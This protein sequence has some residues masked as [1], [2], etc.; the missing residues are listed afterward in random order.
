MDPFGEGHSPNF[1]AFCGLFGQLHDIHRQTGDTIGSFVHDEQNQF[2][3]MFQKGWD[4]L[5]KFEGRNHPTAFMS[6]WQRI[7]SFECV[8]VEKSSSDS[9]GLQLLDI[10][11]W[12]LKRVIDNRQEPRGACAT[13][14]QCLT[15]RSKLVRLDQRDLA[16]KVAT[17]SEYVNS[18]PFT[19]EDEAR[20]KRLL[21][22]IEESRQ[23]RLLSPGQ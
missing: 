9:F 11:L 22:E 7:E 15:Q 2:V 21:S 20:A 1:V 6:D 17:G 19:S 18:L 8:L 14:F 16:Q 3:P 13:L 4:L 23:T 12:L 5:S 10:C